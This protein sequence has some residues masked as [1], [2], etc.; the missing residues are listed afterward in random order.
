MK[1]KLVKQG[2]AT[3]M[4]SLPSKWIKTNNLGKGDEVELI[5]DEKSLTIALA[6]TP[7]SEKA[8]KLNVAGLFPL[9]NRTIIALYIKGY[10]EIE[11]SFKD[12][13]EIK[14]LQNRV[15]KELL[16][17]EIIKQTSNTL[18]IKDVTGLG[19][20]EIDD[21][22]QRIFLILDS[23]IEE[24]IEILEK[25]QLTTPLI[26]S[27]SAINRLTSFCLRNLNKRGYPQFERTAQMYNIVSLLEEIGDCY[28]KIALK[29]AETKL[30]KD[31]IASLKASRGQLALFKEAIFSP[32]QDKLVACAKSH[33]EIKKNLSAKNIIDVYLYQLVDTMIKINNQLFV[34]AALSQ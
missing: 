22:I 31:Q 5:E 2:A 34:Q 1:R 29:T 4:I 23:M 15:I 19:K 28:K 25:K 17:F 3:M 33:K 6:D 8:I 11:I 16:G 18:V 21:L 14:D 7:K 32:T 26:E 9:I 24:L 10:D 13:S 12:P 27:E 30:N 20:Q